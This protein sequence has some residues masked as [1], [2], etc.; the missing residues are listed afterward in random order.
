MLLLDAV[1]SGY[2]GRQRRWKESM[3]AT[4]SRNDDISTFFL[5]GL[6]PQANTSSE[7]PFVG[8]ILA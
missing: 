2:Y 1:P 4:M 6:Q 5:F 3:M 7:E 8:C